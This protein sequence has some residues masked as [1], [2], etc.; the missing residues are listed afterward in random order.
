MVE[1]MA[2]EVLLAEDDLLAF[3]QRQVGRLFVDGPTTTTLSLH[4]P[5]AEGRGRTIELDVLSALEELRLSLDVEMSL[6]FSLHSAIEVIGL[7]L[8]EMHSL[9]GF[10]WVMM[11]LVVID[12]LNH[13]ALILMRIDE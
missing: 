13:H 11:Y 4:F 9:E 1:L 3:G 12:S 5:F 6:V 8:V 10:A 7:Q 2:T